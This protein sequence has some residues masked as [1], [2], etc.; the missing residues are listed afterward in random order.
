MCDVTHTQG[1]SRMV[2][3]P[4]VIELEYQGAISISSDQGDGG[5]HG[6]LQFSV[7][8]GTI[9]NMKIVR[10][11]FHKRHSYIIF[12]YAIPG[13]KNISLF[14]FVSYSIPFG[15]SW[16]PSTCIV[17]RMPRIE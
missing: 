16:L 9:Q 8:Y 6:H 4:Q 5:F 13:Y 15:F 2:L 1:T 17:R 7:A 14:P 12:Q 3:F 10:G 11:I